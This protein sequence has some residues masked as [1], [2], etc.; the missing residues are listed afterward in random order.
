MEIEV[1]F[2]HFRLG[3]IL[4][5]LSLRKPMFY[6]VPAS[7]YVGSHPKDVTFVMYFGLFIKRFKPFT[8]EGRKNE[9]LQNGIMKQV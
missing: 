6:G 1:G 2:A 8:V 5:F 9:A 7:L 4:M 3:F